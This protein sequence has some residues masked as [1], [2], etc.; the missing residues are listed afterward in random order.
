MRKLQTIAAIALIS[1]ATL[2]IAQQT[3]PAPGT[4]TPPP[5]T[6]AQTDGAPLTKSQMKEQKKQQKHEEKAAKESAKAQ[7]A[8]ADAL[9]HQDKATDEEEKVQPGRPR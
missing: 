4:V 7:K 1:F 8:N 9:K 3:E 5:A 6:S 2:G